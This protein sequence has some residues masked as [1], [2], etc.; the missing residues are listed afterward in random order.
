M[1]VKKRPEALATGT[2][3]PLD[4]VEILSD[5][6]LHVRRWNPP[7]RKDRTDGFAHGIPTDMG[8]AREAH[9][10]VPRRAQQDASHRVVL[11]LLL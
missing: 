3:P 4:H 9:R 5:E 7:I 8:D 6:G 1:V 10:S 11:V 2:K